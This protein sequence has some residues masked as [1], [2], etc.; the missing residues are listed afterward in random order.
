MQPMLFEYWWRDESA[1][2]QRRA[3]MASALREAKLGKV[4]R[5]SSGA[6]RL[7]GTVRTGRREPG[8]VQAGALA[9]RQ[10]VTGHVS[11]PVTGSIYGRRG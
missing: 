3:E 10:W 7:L 4:S 9:F 8:R 5:R 2:L 1:R 6:G 11:L